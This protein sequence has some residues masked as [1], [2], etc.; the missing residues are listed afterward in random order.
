[1]EKQKDNFML[2]E[3]VSGRIYISTSCVTDEPEGLGKIDKLGPVVETSTITPETRL[4]IGL[5]ES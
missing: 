2:V 4:N 5:F 1:M 3:G